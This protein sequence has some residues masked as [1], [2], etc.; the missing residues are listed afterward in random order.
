MISES[1]LFRCLP[2]KSRMKGCLWIG[3]CVP[4]FL[5][6]RS[7]VGFV[8]ICVVCLGQGT[9]VRIGSADRELLYKSE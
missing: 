8:S 4:F 7:S 5:L 9:H 1:M 3:C 6:S 2:G